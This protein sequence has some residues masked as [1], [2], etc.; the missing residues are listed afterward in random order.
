ML[1]KIL[2]TAVFFLFSLSGLSRDDLTNGERE[3]VKKV[4]SLTTNFLKAER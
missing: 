1:I 4:S 2:S 3:K